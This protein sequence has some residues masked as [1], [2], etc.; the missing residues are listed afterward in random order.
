MLSSLR[1][2]GT[3]IVLTAFALV[4]RTL[5][6]DGPVRPNILFA[7][8]DDWG[9]PHAGAYGDKVIK[10]PTFDRLAREGVLILHAFVS[11]PSCTPCR[12]SIL[13]GQQFYRLGQGANLWSTLDIK[14][15]NFMH[16]L[17]DAGYEIGHWRKSWGP[18]DYEVGG[19]TEHPCGPESEFTNFMAKRDDSKPFCF[20]FGTSDPHRGYKLN[21][22]RES[23][24]E[25]D[26]VHVPKFYP[27]EEVIRSDIAD[28]YFEV[29]R[30][31]SDVSAAIKLLQDAGQLENTIVIMTGDHGMPFPRCKGNLYDWGARVPLA[32]RWAKRIPAGRALTDFISLTDLAPTLLTAADC[33]IPDV[34]TGKNLLP[35]L[36][37]SKNGRVD[38]AHDFI[39]MGRERH[40][41]AQKLPSTDGY[42]SRAIRNDRW[43]L[44]LNLKPDRWPVG[45]PE[46]ATHSMAVHADTDG[47]PSK[48]FLVE[49]KS[50]PAIRKYYDLSFA[51]RPAIELYD[52]QA[53]PDNVNNLADDPQYAQTIK[54]LSE[55]LA[56]YLGKTG[57]PRFT[58]QPV[59]FDEFP[60]QGGG[61]ER[62]T[63]SSGRVELEDVVAELAEEIDALHEEG[64]EKDWSAERREFVE[65]I[66]ELTREIEERRYEGEDNWAKHLVGRRDYFEGILPMLDEILE[67]EQSLDK[68]QAGQDFDQAEQFEDK[69]EG[70]AEKFWQAERIGEM[71]GRLSELKVE[72]D[73]LAQ[74][75]EDNARP[76]VEAFVADQEDLLKLLRDLYKIVETDDD[77]RIEK[78]EKQVD[79]REESLLLRIEAFHLER[80]LAEARQEGGNVQ[81]LEAELQQIHKALQELNGGS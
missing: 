73:E 35:I 71:E 15:P 45:V 64:E 79:Q 61:L 27:N 31:D 38:A 23:G 41:P 77:K 69:L 22:G 13:T 40:V 50:D 21:S 53:D 17:R 57:D 1:C 33:Q 74:E 19:Y 47:G 8:A 48:S 34:M 62:E 55:Q 28:Y 6:A 26:A 68:A 59:E 60:Y 58:S 24:I 65:R 42:P 3:M 4:P 66:E 18:G 46:G 9:W 14:H 80:N 36:T 54:T 37:S 75:G 5:L 49:H 44:I 78:L 67:L 70:M 30:W 32:I 39:V 10:T 81:E 63:W 11:S 51:K 12:N 29:Q 72:K 52:C 7:L 43:L 76:R 56:E 25:L 16:M 20:W 2:H